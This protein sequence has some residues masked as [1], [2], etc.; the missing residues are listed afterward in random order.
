MFARTGRGETL[1]HQLPC[2]YSLTAGDETSRVITLSGDCLLCWAETRIQA[3]TVT[4][5]VYRS[6]WDKDIG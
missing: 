4:V 1:S 2:G 3:V 5:T 6:L